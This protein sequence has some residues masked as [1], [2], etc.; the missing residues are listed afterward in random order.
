MKGTILFKFTKLLIYVDNIDITRTTTRDVRT[1]FIYKHSLFSL[2]KTG[3]LKTANHRGNALTVQ[4]N[5]L[6]SPCLVD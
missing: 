5:D 6:T 2:T 4:G 1:A 3:P